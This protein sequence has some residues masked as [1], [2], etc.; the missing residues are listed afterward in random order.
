[1]VKEISYADTRLLTDDRVADPV[2]AHAQTLVLIN[3]LDVVHL[4]TADEHSDPRLAMLLIGPASQIVLLAVSADLVELDEVE[5][6]VEEIERR[7]T[8]RLPPLKAINEAA[9]KGMHSV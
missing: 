2:M 9:A 6:V 7:N 4:P 8:E 3:A 1:V 5:S